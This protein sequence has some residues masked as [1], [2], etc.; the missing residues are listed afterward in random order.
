L[1]APEPSTWALKTKPPTLQPW[2]AQAAVNTVPYPK[3]V[4]MR[5]RWLACRSVCLL[6]DKTGDC[7]DSERPLSL[8]T[9]SKLA[10]CTHYTFFFFFPALLPRLRTD[11]PVWTLE[12]GQTALF[13]VLQPTL[14]FWKKKYIYIYIHICTE[15]LLGSCVF[16]VLSTWFLHFDLYSSYPLLCS[17]VSVAL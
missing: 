15:V 10:K 1:L 2:R 9:C 11:G 3:L 6:R 12:T 8:A 7:I 14:C 4:G 5:S 17:F 16:S 13:P